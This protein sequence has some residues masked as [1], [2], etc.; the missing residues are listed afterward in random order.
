MSKKVIGTARKARPLCGATESWW[1]ENPADIE[2]YARACSTTLAAR[3]DKRQL[4]GWLR[5]IG[6]VVEK[7]P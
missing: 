6:Y 1:Y 4:I 5:R 7:K 3:I 2:V